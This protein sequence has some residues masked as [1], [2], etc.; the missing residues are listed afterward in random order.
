[1]HLAY[2]DESGDAGVT[3]GSSTY[4]LACIL[5]DE[6]NWLPALD[7]VISFRRFLKS[8]VGIPMVQ[9]LKANYLLHNSGPWLTKNPLGSSIRGRIYNMSL[10]LQ[11]KLDLTVFGVVIDKAKLAAP[12]AEPPAMFAW[13]RMVERLERFSTNNKSS[14]VLVHDQGDGDLVRK[15]ARRARR[16]GIVGA[17]YGPGSLK[18]PFALLLDDPV[19]RNSRH[20][21]LLQLADLDAYAAFRRCYPPP[22]RNQ[23][24]I[25]SQTW[26]L[27]GSARLLAVNKL[28]GGPAGIVWQPK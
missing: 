23:Q 26:D 13:M 14:I 3:G 20:S 8:Q 22:A 6:D 24:I 1:M 28:A 21:Y 15:I 27:L 9:E 12:G 2:V 11:E 16:L 10:R 17:H 7:G 18:R 4:A 5:I 19:S 25:R